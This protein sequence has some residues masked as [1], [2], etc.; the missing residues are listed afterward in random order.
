DYLFISYEEPFCMAEANTDGTGSVDIGDLTTLIDYLFISFDAPAS[1]PT[2]IGSVL[3][4][5]PGS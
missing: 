4:V 3:K 1:C 2:P 5:P